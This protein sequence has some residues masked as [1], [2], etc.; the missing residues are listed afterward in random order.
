MQ[1]GWAERVKRATRAEKVSETCKSCVHSEL[2]CGTEVG[3]ETK[4][5][6]AQMLKGGIE[7]WKLSWFHS[8]FPVS[9]FKASC[10]CAR[11]Q[12][13]QLTQKE[14]FTKVYMDNVF[15]LLHSASLPPYKPLDSKA[16]EVRS[17]LYLPDVC[18]NASWS[19]FFF[20]SRLQV[21]LNFRKRLLIHSVNA[22]TRM[23][24]TILD[25]QFSPHL[26]QRNQ[27]KDRKSWSAQFQ[28]M[29]HLVEEFRTTNG[30]KSESVCRQFVV[31]VWMGRLVATSCAKQ[32]STKV[33]KNTTDEQED[34]T[35][36]LSRL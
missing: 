17:A 21:Q 8:R 36:S 33:K 32:T 15:P 28:E 26:N 1:A 12:K 9:R 29:Q 24:Q 16:E 7:E 25:L 22:Q 5:A 27:R 11:W 2:W 13:D 23:H 4:C 34:H 3:M 30:C 35:L 14:L 20:A 6:G 18:T 10:Y 31:L 19:T